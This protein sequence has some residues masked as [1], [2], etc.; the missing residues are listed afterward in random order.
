MHMSHHDNNI[1]EQSYCKGGNYRRVTKKAPHREASDMEP[2]FSPSRA[3]HRGKYP[4]IA[5]QFTSTTCFFC[6]S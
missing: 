1:C 6:V 5:M 2:Y 4:L 3:L